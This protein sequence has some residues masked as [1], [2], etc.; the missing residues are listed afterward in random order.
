MKRTTA[1][2]AALLWGASWGAPPAASQAPPDAPAQLLEDVARTKHNLSSIAPDQILSSA[3]EPKPGGSRLVSSPETTEI[4]VFCHTPHGASSEAT[5]SV[6]APIW[7]RS[8]SQANFQL[9][10]QVW[11]RSFEGKLNSNQPTG[12]SR[13]CLSCHDGTIALG[14][15]RNTPGSGGFEAELGIQYATGVTAPF[16]AGS[17]P[18]GSGALGQDTRRLG[19]DL[20][21]DHPISFVYDEALVSVDKELVNP[22]PPLHPPQKVGDEPLF[23]QG[24][25]PMRRYSGTDLN[26]FDSVQCTSVRSI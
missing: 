4:C 21:N 6:Q 19:V 26:T 9:Y 22:G 16:P 7:N 13:L 23:P 3:T 15:L 5:S 2:L 17:I 25:G 14:A 8:L 20:R 11:S 18:E 12:Y 10:D 1:L 24:I